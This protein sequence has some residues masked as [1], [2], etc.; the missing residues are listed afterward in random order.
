MSDDKFSLEQIRRYWAQQAVAHGQSPMASWSDFNVIELEIREILKYLGEDERVLDIGCANGYSA[1][2]FAAQKRIAIRGLDCIPEM[3]TEA[4]ARLKNVMPSLRGTVE[5]DIGDITKLN[6]PDDTY[7]KVV[8]IRVIIGL[9]DWPRQAQALGECVRVLKPGGVLLLS[10]ATL[11]GWGRL[12]ALRYEWGLPE[13][14]MPPFNWYLDLDEVCREVA[15]RLE[16]VA[17]VDFASTY[18]VGTRVLKPLLTQALGAR[19]DVANPDMEWNR[20]FA[21]LPSAGDY[22]TQKLFVFRKR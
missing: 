18:Y 20:W 12:N 10:E 11:Q 3:I 13:I 21:Q 14:P 7:D 5:F 15:S 6:E 4:R 9:G 22:G 8:V 1:V 19:V 16:L 2:Q 17:L